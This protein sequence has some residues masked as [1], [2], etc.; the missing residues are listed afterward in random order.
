[1]AQQIVAFQIS[2]PTAHIKELPFRLRMPS[3]HQHAAE[4]LVLR[5]EVGKYSAEHTNENHTQDQSDV[6]LRSDMGE[7]KIWGSWRSEL[8]VP[9]HS[10]HSDGHI[11]SPRCMWYKAST[12]LTLFLSPL[13]KSG[14]LDSPVL[15]PPLLN[16]PS[17]LHPPWVGFFWIR[18]F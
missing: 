17:P 11:F 8:H 12:F 13:P 2:I 5:T 15:N 10:V 4:Y 6:I 7:S 16:Q 1:M 14:V 18:P 9:S 3:R